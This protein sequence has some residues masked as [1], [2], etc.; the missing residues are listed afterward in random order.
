M[1]A[2]LKGV[3]IGVVVKIIQLLWA[4]FRSK[5][6]AH[7]ANSEKK[8]NQ[9]KNKEIRKKVDDAETT[10]E[11]QDALDDAA[12]RFGRGRRM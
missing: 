1:T 12:G 9:K 7:K 6:D 3:V 4:N 8:K 10:D 5:W 2:W 11:M